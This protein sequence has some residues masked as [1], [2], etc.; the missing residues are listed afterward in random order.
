[1]PA[2]A[3]PRLDEQGGDEAGAAGVLGQA[4]VRGGDF[5][6]GRP[7]RDAEPDGELALGGDVDLAA[8]VVDGL[9]PGADE[10]GGVQLGQGVLAEE[11][12]VGGVPGFALDA[13]DLRGVGQVGGAD[14][15]VAHGCELS[16]ARFCRWWVAP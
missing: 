5:A 1:M 15:G 12:L 10:V 13:G 4:A 3:P 7:A 8:R 16:G 6:F 9:G 14:G 2:P 11:V